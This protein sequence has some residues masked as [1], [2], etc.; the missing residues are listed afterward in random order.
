MRASTRFLAVALV[1]GSLATACSSDTKAATTTTSAAP[2]SSTA[3]IVEGGKIGNCEIKGKKGSSPVT[4]V[5][6]GQL[7]VQ[8][9]LPAPGWFNGETPEAI[10]D[11]Y[12]FCMA[13]NIAW[14]AGLDKVV[15]ENVDFG[16]LQSAQTKDFDLAL[17]EISITDKRKQ[18]VD[19]SSPY[20]G[21]D[22][23][24]L[25]KS[26]TK[27]ADNTALK[28]LKIGI[29]E[30][31]TGGDFVLANVSKGAKSFPDSAT[32]FSALEAGTIDVAMTDTAIVL[33]KAGDSKGA[34][35]VVG[36]YKTGESYGAIFPKAADNNSKWDAIIKALIADKTLD[37]LQTT[38][39]ASL[40]KGDPAKVPYFT[41]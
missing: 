30:A 17:A 4:P 21:S 3:V 10:K 36:Q 15:L 8:T 29:Q 22:I 35:E 1:F 12:E 32:L 7:T 34:L 16:A 39:L 20:F 26:G 24:V 23:G 33:G 2:A 18:V 5:K 38:Y 37:G 28:A 6:A 25:V 13:A 11:G 27:V 31:T 40:W 9:S 14:R 19:F 41:A